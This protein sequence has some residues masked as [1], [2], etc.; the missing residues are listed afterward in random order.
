M[1]DKLDPENY[2][3]S[4]RSIAFKKNAWKK[5]GMYPEWMDRGEDLHFAKKLKL[6]KLKFKFVKNAIVSWPQRKNIIEAFKQFFGYAKGDG[7]AMNIR[8]NVILL[9]LRYF[10]LFYLF[11]ISIIEKS[12]SLLLFILILSLMYVYW[13]IRKNYKYIKSYKAF[14]Y[15]PLLQFTADLAVLTGTLSGIFN[16][17]KKR[18]I[19]KDIRNYRF[20]IFI[21]F[22]YVFL[23]FS[24]IKFGIPNINH[25]Y[26]Y[27]MDE[28]HQLSA[29]A[30]TFIH[31]TPNMFGSANGTILK[32][33]KMFSLFIKF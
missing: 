7:S 16:R 18:K 15:L 27:H 31:G 23:V 9:Y 29:V 25:P 14:F 3:P 11:F 30:D 33:I 4:S 32:I 6:K 26:P 2:L 21:C 10:L 5:A 24:T 22:I 20:L 17:L 13:A 28:W 1:P 12:K 8:T 19:K